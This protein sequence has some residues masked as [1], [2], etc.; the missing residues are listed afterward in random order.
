M[1]VE[2]KAD[3]TIDKVK[4]HITEAYKGLLDIL[5]DNVDGADDFAES[6]KSDFPDIIHTLLDI[7]RKI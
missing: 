4:E 3:Q 6:Y 2:T 5:E 7:K 1:G